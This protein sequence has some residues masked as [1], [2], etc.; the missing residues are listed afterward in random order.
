MWGDGIAATHPF[1]VGVFLPW[2]AAL[3]WRGPRGDGIELEGDGQEWLHLQAPSLVE[4]QR[5][6]VSA[7]GRGKG[8]IFEKC[9]AG[10]RHLPAGYL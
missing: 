6:G 9:E 8:G 5:A 10:I 1:G 3:S 4:G 2:A 7:E